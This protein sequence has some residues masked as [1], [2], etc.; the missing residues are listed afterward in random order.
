MCAPHTEPFGER[1]GSPI[2]RQRSPLNADRRVQ[3]ADSTL[4]GGE[5]LSQDHVVGGYQIRRRA[6][7]ELV[8]VELDEL[9]QK[10]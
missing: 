2:L 6:A 3:V 4:G 8:E 1:A 9:V 10:R 5:Q 7:A